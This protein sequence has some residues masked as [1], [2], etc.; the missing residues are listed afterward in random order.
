MIAMALALEPKLLI[1]DEP[2]T[3]LDVTIQAQV[4]ELISRLTTE[5]GTSLILITHDLGVV[6]GMTD[7]INVMYAGFVVETATTGDLFDRP[8]HPYT[9]G[10]LHSMPRVDEREG[11]PLI[12]I[13]G[14]PPDMRQRTPRLP[15]RAALRLAARAV[16]DATTPRCCRCTRASRSWRPAP[17]RPTCV[18]CHNPPLPDEALAGRPDAARLAARTRTRGRAGRAGHAR[19]ARRRGR[20]PGRHRVTEQPLLEVK[21]LKVWFRITEGMIRE[22]HVG[23]VRA[24]DGV[25]FQLRRGETLGLVGESGLRQEHDRA[26]D[27]SPVQAD[28][29]HDHLRRPGRHERRGRR[30]AQAAAPVPDDLPGPVRVAG[31]ADDRRRDRRRAAGRPRRRHEGGAARA[32]PRAAGDRGPQPR[33][34]RPLPARVLR[35][36]AAAHRGGAGARAGPRPDRRRRADLRARRVDPGPGD[37]PAREAPGPARADLPVHRPRPVG[38]PPHQRPDRG[39]VPRADRGARAVEGA[40]RRPL[41]PYAVALLSAVPIPDP[42]VERRRRRIILKGDVPSPVNPPSGCH[43]HTRCWLRERLGNPERCS[44]EIPLLRELSTGPRGRVPLRGGG[45]GVEGAAP[46]DRPGRRGPGGARAVAR[47]RPPT[48]PVSVRRTPDVAA[49]RAAADAPRRCRAG[50]SSSPPTGPAAAVAGPAGPRL[51][52]AA[53]PDRPR[54][55]RAPPRG[56][57]GEPRAPPRSCST[58]RAAGGAG[59]GRVPGARADRVPAPGPRRRGRDAARRPAAGP[60]LARRPRACRRSCRSSRSRRT[61][62]C[63]SPRPC[64]R[65]ASSATS[66]ARSTCR[67]TG[68]STSGGSSPRATWCARCRRGSG[69]ASGWRCARTSGT[70]STPQLLALDGAQVLINVSSSPGRDLALTHEVGL[71]TATSWRDADADLRPAHDVVR[72]VLQ[73]GRASTRACRSGVGRRSSRRPGAPLFSAPMFEEGLFCVD[74]DLAD[75]RRERIALPL[76]RDER[77]ELVAREW[78]RLIA[79]RAGLADDTTAE[80]GAAAGLRRG[81]RPVTDDAPSPCSSCPTSSRSTPASRGGSIAEFIRGQ[82]RQAGFEQGG[83]RAVGRDRLRRSSRT[84]WPRRSAPSSCCA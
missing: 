31:P 74:V 65:T 69:S 35:R 41:H 50:R 52:R 4:L 58:R 60:S 32:G 76:L 44:A 2:T 20:G 10:L 34:R 62:G 9:V 24:V 29:R 13:E 75:V 84:S 8:S 53:P 26:G 78:R 47:P 73:P 45:R 80:P 39:D 3:A 27:R 19:R 67:R 82:L 77:P 7:R 30:A 37:Q 63:S 54:P 33:L 59:P 38:R 12:P 68:C 72:G 6:A 14:R 21:D 5:T 61:T 70:S 56:P 18:A 22:R 46:G 66:T 11:E 71:G 55:A 28:R 79:E 48:V 17:P 43:F 42:K 23:D 16:L 40:Q 36:P 83:P 25:S 49:P 1:A 15:V 51:G 81:G 57:R 64:S